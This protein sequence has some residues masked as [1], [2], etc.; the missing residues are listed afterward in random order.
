MLPN[1]PRCLGRV[2]GG[3]SEVRAYT[4]GATGLSLAVN[5]RTPPGSTRPVMDVHG[6]QVRIA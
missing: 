2:R 5:G 1:H 4:R 3:R 6:A